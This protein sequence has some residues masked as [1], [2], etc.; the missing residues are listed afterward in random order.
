MERQ[1]LLY[2]EIEIIRRCPGACIGRASI[3]ALYHNLGGFQMALRYFLEPDN[4]QRLFPLEFWF[5]NEFVA[6]YYN[7]V[8]STAGWCGIILEENQY[9]EE[10]SFWVFYELFDAFKALSIQHCHCATLDKEH[11][12]HHCTSERAPRRL[13]PPDYKKT[14]PMYLDPVEVYIIE[15]TDSAG[16]LCMVNTEAQH[17]LQRWIY[18]NRDCAEEYIKSCFGSSLSW[19]N[20]EADNIEFYKELVCY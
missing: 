4:P 11:I 10:K 12:H 5:F 13:L 3:T 2:K 15:L 17:R 8:E 20:I 18:K 16:F 6:R 19:E 7:W 1:E 9:D 14:E